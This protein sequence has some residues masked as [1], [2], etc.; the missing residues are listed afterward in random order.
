[1]SELFVKVKNRRAET[2]KNERAKQRNATRKATKRTEAEARQKRFD[3]LPDT[4]KDVR[5]AAR[6]ATQKLF[7]V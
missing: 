4:E 1:M 2:G 5:R 3:A 6:L 7:G